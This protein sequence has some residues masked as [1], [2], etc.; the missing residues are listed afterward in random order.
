MFSMAKNSM[1]LFARGKLF[2]DLGSVIVKAIIGILI[3]A[4]LFL[5]CRYYLFLGM[6]WEGPGHIWLSAGVA[7]FLGGALQPYLFKDLKYA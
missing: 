3:T 7:A 2:K 4:L 5:A 6:G 1:I